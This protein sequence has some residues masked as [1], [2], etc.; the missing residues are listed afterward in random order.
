M[1]FLCKDIKK[2]FLKRFTRSTVWKL[3]LIKNI[4][5]D[6]VKHHVNL[7][8]S[9]RKHAFKIDEVLENV[10]KDLL[11]HWERSTLPLLSKQRIKRKVT[12]IY[13]DYKDVM[14]NENAWFKM[15]T[16]EA[17]RLFDICKCSCIGEMSC[18]CEANLSASQHQFYRDQV[19]NRTLTLNRKLFLFSA[20]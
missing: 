12:K 6:F 2:R 20:C 5:Y 10:I 13:E 19:E 3:P 11:S 1:P 9:K 16:S 15:E 4:V 8:S 14:N 7:E 17:Q 18:Q